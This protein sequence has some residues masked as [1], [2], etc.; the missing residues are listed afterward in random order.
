MEKAALIRGVLLTGLL[1]LATAPEARAAE[2]TVY[3]DYWPNVLRISG[4]DTEV[5]EGQSGYLNFVISNVSQSAEVLNY[6][7]TVG[8]TTG[9]NT[10]W[11]Q[12]AGYGTLAGYTDCE[13]LANSVLAS[14]SACSLVAKFTTDTG[15]DLGPR[16]DGSTPFTLKVNVGGFSNTF[17]VRTMNVLVD[18]VPEPTTWAMVLIGFGVIG[19]ATRRRQNVSITYA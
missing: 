14:G 15:P 9:D 18:D 17:V 12:S 19:F 8:A 2:P 16:A 4:V 11:A 6:G 10:D 1:L 3:V 13:G 5:L 7:L